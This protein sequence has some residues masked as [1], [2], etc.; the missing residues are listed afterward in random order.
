MVNAL[1]Q[2][3]LVKKRIQDTNLSGGQNVQPNQNKEVNIFAS[4][5]ET[6]GVQSA[7]QNSANIFATDAV[8]QGVQ[9]QTSKAPSLDLNKFFDNAAM[10]G[11]DF[12][13]KTDAA[14]DKTADKADGKE[15]NRH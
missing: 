13:S 1:N 15:K 4:A 7:K 9:A 3:L 2:Q 6:Q 12:S 10:Y 14:K 11:V 5:P 8:K